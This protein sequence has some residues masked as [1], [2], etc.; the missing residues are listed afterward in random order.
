[1]RDRRRNSGTAVQDVTP[2]GSATF[3]NRMTLQI[4]GRWWAARPTGQQ[5]SLFVPGSG[6]GEHAAS[7]VFWPEL[8][9]SG[10][11]PDRQ[12]LG[13]REIPRVR[14]QSDRSRGVAYHLRS[15]NEALIR[16]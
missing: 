2:N 8:S 15:S 3:V 11:S 1:M 14:A 5:E 7:I 13:R 10:P 16:F 6:E 4:L 9:S 12:G